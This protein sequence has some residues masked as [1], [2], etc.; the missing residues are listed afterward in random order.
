M[1]KKTEDTNYVSLHREN[2]FRLSKQRLKK[3][4][5]VI[6]LCSLLCILAF[7]IFSPFALIVFFT[8]PAISVMRDIISI[9]RL[10]FLPEREANIKHEM[11][12]IAKK[13]EKSVED[14][15]ETKIVNQMKKKAITFFKAVKGS[16]FNDSYSE[17]KSNEQYALYRNISIGVVAIIGIS[18]LIFGAPYMLIVLGCGIATTSFASM[19]SELASSSINRNI[20]N[21]AEKFYKNETPKKSQEHEVVSRA[22]SREDNSQVAGLMGQKNQDKQ[23]TSERS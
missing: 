12:N 11:S 19:S 4:L 2:K 15:K 10:K 16:F 7:G 9:V 13:E 14:T 3:K 1:G 22:N 20:V 23:N 18:L 8:I 5:P 6:G 21:N 17:T